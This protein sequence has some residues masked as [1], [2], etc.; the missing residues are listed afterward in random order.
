MAGSDVLGLLDQE[1]QSYKGSREAR[2]GLRRWKE[3]DE[4][5]DLIHDL[6]AVVTTARGPRSEGS[7]E[8]LLALLM[9]APTDPVAARVALQAIVP[10]LGGVAR[11]YRLRWGREETA[12]MAVAAA[13]E[14]V[15]RY[16]YHRP[17]S[18]MGNLVRDV[19]HD[20]YELRLKEVAQD[21]ALS[22]VRADHQSG[23]RTSVDTEPPAE[24]LVSVLADAVGM[25]VI[26][27]RQA[28]LIYR[29]RVLGVSTQT[30]AEAEGL[31]PCTIRKH[32]REAEQ[33][34]VAS[35]RAVA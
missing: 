4:S 15:L 6:D 20:L 24:E 28:Q 2:G 27:R 7:D 29:R 14:R 1:W 8:I 12:S 18:P 35:M 5:F 31:Q 21:A 34:L 19:R 23:E 3:C 13:Y 10:G 11:T 9:M 22:K 32:R 17:G 16:S 26:G 30:L 25:G 33:V